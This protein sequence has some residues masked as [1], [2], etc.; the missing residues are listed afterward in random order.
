MRPIPFEI[1]T[2][3]CSQDGNFL[4]ASARAGAALAL[5]SAGCIIQSNDSIPPTNAEMN[6][7]AYETIILC[8]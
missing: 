4:K 2:H 8:A 1:R 6:L 3:A 5:G 7:R